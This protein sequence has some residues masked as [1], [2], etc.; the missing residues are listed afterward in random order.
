MQTSRD[1]AIRKLI[2][3]FRTYGYEGTTL[4]L[5]SKM[6]GLGKASLYH[7]FPK[8]KQEMAEAVLVHLYQMFGEIVLKPLQEDT[9]PRDRLRGMC[10]GLNQFYD[11]GQAACLIAVFSLGGEESMFREPVKR[12]LQEWVECLEKI[13][14]EAG[15]DRAKQRA[16][17]AVMQVQG[18]LIVTQVL[19]DTL[20]FEKMLA[21]LPEKLLEGSQKDSIMVS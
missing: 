3:V 6:T 17:E 16:E 20:P 13:L 12:A 21:E 1:E 2:K 18:G 11:R 9:L 19:G 7:H 15:C 5:I 10:E 4:S 8:G 14:L